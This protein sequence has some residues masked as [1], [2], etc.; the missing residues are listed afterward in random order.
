MLAM[1]SIF[2]VDCSSMHSSVTAD[3]LMIHWLFTMRFLSLRKI[4]FDGER[5]FDIGLCITSLA[6]PRVTLSRT[7]TKGNL[8]GRLGLTQFSFHIT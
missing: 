4:G 5:I 8:H 3:S 1:G 6:L 2:M 7:G